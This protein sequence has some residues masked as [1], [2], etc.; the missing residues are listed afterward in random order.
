MSS[1]FNLKSNKKLHTNT[2][3]C[4]YIY[5]HKSQNVCLLFKHCRVLSH[6]GLITIR[7][8]NIYLYLFDLFIIFALCELFTHHMLTIIDIMCRIFPCIGEL[9][10]VEYLHPVTKVFIQVAASNS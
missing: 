4:K 3:V 9:I 10:A 8:S 5:T 6:T 1:I 2:F 7:I